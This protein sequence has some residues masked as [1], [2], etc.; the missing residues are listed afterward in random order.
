MQCEIC[1]HYTAYFIVVD[2]LSG[3]TTAM[4]HPCEAR[5]AT[6]TYHQTLKYQKPVSKKQIRERAD[7]IPN[8]WHHL[9]APGRPIATYSTKSERLEIRLSNEELRELD[10]IIKDLEKVESDEPTP[11]RTGVIRQALKY[12]GQMV[13]EAKEKQAI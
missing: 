8:S 1:N 9:R 13:Q 12:Y 5:E 7:M 6:P 3:E 10:S 2:T 11:T 4:C